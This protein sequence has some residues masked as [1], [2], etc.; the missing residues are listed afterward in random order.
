M[1]FFISKDETFELYDAYNIC[2]ERG[3]TLNLTILGAWNKY[4]GLNIMLTGTKFE[5]RSNF[6]GMTVRT[7]FLR[8]IHRRYLLLFYKL[9]FKIVSIGI[10][11]LH[12][13]AN[14]N[15]KTY[16]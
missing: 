11:N 15:Q 16:P 3:G 7:S 1:S 5:R 2:K 8:V 12:F 10:V 14:I 13:R 6:H 4:E 9:K